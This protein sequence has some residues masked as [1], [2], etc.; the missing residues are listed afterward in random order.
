MNP[1]IQPLHGDI[2]HL[3]KRIPDFEL[4]YETISHKKVSCEYNVAMAIPVGKKVYA[5][6]T[7]HQ[8]NDVCYLFDLNKDK[9]ISRGYNININFDPSLSL[10]T[11]LYGTVIDEDEL[12]VNSRKWFIVEDIFF[13]K[14]IPLKKS[15]LHE[16]LEFIED[17]FS[18]V[19]RDFTKSPAFL[20]MLPVMW[21]FKIQDGDELPVSVP[22]DV[23]KTIPYSIHHIHYRSLH[24]IMLYLNVNLTRK[25]N[26]THIPSDMRSK[27]VHKFDTIELIIDT[28]KPQ[29]K[30]TAVFQVT[31][32]IQFD[33]YHLFAFWKNNRPIYYNLAYVPN[34][35]SSVFLNG[36]FRNIRENQNLD[37][38]EESEDEE[39]FQNM[40]ED[41]Y[42]NINKVIK[43]ECVFNRKFKKW[44]PVRVAD[45][46]ARVVHISKLVKNVVM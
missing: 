34:Y 1:S 4:S 21:E 7:F 3:I 9:K 11:L 29:Y 42:V 8:A 43:M 5:W 13:F 33:I 46:N 16:K 24:K 39:D 44:V 25:L 37:Y 18:F 41:K 27:P 12:D 10:G 17:F 6:F 19:E 20:F 15:T 14:G 2:G 45:K 31:A 30:L 32:D 26:V 28:F 35:K 38:I 22:E 40:N 23:L 36:L